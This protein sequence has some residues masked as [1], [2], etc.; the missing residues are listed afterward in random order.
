M[1]KSKSC[2]Y[3]SWMWR[4]G[5]NMG[6]AIIRHL[7]HSHAKGT[8]PLK[9]IWG[10]K[11]FEKNNEKY[12]LGGKWT[13]LYF[14]ASDWVPQQMELLTMIRWIEVLLMY[15]KIAC[16]LYWATFNMAHWTFH[17]SYFTRLSQ[18]DLSEL[19][20]ANYVN[21]CRLQIAPQIHQNTLKF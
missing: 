12:Y 19:G 9:S 11:A 20:I 5:R 8:S 2:K 18:H 10:E 16:L 17:S 14:L 6:S 21:L 13:R 1:D 15:I 7:A 4:R 3:L